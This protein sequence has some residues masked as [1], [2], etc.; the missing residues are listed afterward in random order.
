M[1]SLDD[2]YQ[3]IAQ[4]ANDKGLTLIDDLPV[5]SRFPTIVWKGEWQEYL[6][7]AAQ[8]QASLLYAK[9]WIYIPE[10]LID[11]VIDE[12]KNHSVIDDDDEINEVEGFSKTVGSHEWWQVRLKEAIEPWGN[13]RSEVFGI[14]VL[15]IKESVAHLWSCDAEWYLE[16]KL[17]FENAIEQAEEVDDGNRIILSKETTLRFH[18]YAKQVAQ[19]PRFAD[20]KSIEKRMYMVSELFPDIENDFPENY[21]PAFNVAKRAELIY[22]WEIEPKEKILVVERVKQLHEQGESI[23]NIAAILKITEAK[24]KAAV[25][26]SSQI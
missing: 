19:H 17:A 20:A 4:F 23:K 11:E 5:L 12:Q 16:H 3:S 1:P 2:I 6:N 13:H 10:A 22:W 9:K 18:E 7:C 8:V 25:Q 21:R 26:A 15:W 24:V 14:T